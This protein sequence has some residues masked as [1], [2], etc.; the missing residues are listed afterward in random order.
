MKLRIRQIA[1]LTLAGLTIG[2]ALVG[3]ETLL[4]AN[5]AIGKAI[6]LAVVACL[7]VASFLT[8]TGKG[9]HQK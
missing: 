1:G 7:L 2:L 4:E 3:M 5:E 9:R 6:G 8:D